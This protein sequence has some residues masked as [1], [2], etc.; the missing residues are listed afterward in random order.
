MSGVVDFLEDVGHAIS[1]AVEDFIDAVVYVLWDVLVVGALE[2]TFALLGITDE[3]VITTQKSSSLIFGDNTVDVIK[4]ANVRAVISMVKSGG[5]FFG[6]YMRE[7][8]LTKA[9]ITSFYRFAKQGRYIHGLPNMVVK[10]DDSDSATIDLALNTEIGSPSTR[11]SNLVQVP[12][13]EQYFKDK[14]Q[15]PPYNY[16]PWKNAL[17]FT[18]PYGVSRDDY[19]I[20]SVVYDG[21]LTQYE[22]N[23][24]RIAE[25]AL[26]TIEGPTQITEG[27]SATYTITS[28]KVIPPGNTI[29]VNLNY[30]GTALASSYTQIPTAIILA[31]NTNT[32]ITINTNEDSVSQGVRDLIITISTV[33]NIPPVFEAVGLGVQSSTTT[34]IRDDEGLL[35]TMSSHTAIEASGNA[36]IPVKLEA[37]STGAF[38]VD[39]EL[40]DGTAVGGLDFDGTSGTLNFTGS[41]GEIQNIS[42]PI[43]S[44]A[45]DDKEQF[46]IQF[47]SCSDPLV[48]FSATSIVTIVDN[49]EVVNSPSTVVLNDVII[50]PSYSREYSR[51]IT[52]HLNSAPSSEWFYWIYPFSNNTYPGINFTNKVLTNLSMLPVAVLRKNKVFVDTDKTTKEYK[53]TKQLVDKLGLDMSTIIKNTKENPDIGS[54]D[55][56]FINFALSPSSTEEV[57]SKY[58]WL[59]FYDLIIINKIHSNTGGYTARFTEQDVNTVIVWSKYS[60]EKNLVGLP[61]VNEYSH[62]IEVIPAVGNESSDSVLTITRKIGTT[63][64]YEQ[65]IVKTL[66]GYTAIEFEGFHKVAL[67]KIGDDNF[68]FPVSHFILNQLDPVEQMVLYQHILRI[69]AYAIQITPVDWYKTDDFLKLFNFGLIVINIL[70]AGIASGPIEVFKQLLI[71]YLLT[72]LVIFVAELTGN[73]EL[74]ALVGFVAALALSGDS[75]ELSSLFDFPSAEALLNASTNFAD[76]LTAAYN[77][78]SEGLVEDLKELNEKA[79]IRLKEVEDARPEDSAITSEFLVALNSVDTTVYPSVK[80]QYNFDLVFN[81]DRII[82][83]YYDTNFRIGVI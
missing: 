69:D 63:N 68:T 4:Q 73:E 44:D 36:I 41:L 70:S 10:G 62:S 64:F 45:P 43:N 67:N 30:S 35:L 20:N 71:N 54:I 51:I 55:D 12:T 14:F 42:V 76:N 28:N 48:D 24:S 17:T 1:D 65:I 49:S 16:I 74:A 27:D 2:E 26:F 77:V 81:Y 56:L 9:Q 33:D 52:Y 46:T 21:G 22:I 78:E 32:N 47:T 31:G 13:H 39:Y 83:D 60:H 15:S 66:N 61:F 40:I 34:L 50:E 25:E 72:E 82:K 3:T 58:L 7:T 79:E 75:S 11:L 38:T 59:L 53:S 23:I 29:T 5:S 8:R 80:G 18:D 6:W 37:A 19:S 57:V